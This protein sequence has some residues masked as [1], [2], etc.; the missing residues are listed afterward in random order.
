MEGPC[1]CYI[2]IPIQT[3]DH[4]GKHAE[5]CQVRIITDVDV[6]LKCHWG[7]LIITQAKV[8]KKDV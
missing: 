7:R 4:L 1:M 5:K 2:F 6:V 8:K 3:D